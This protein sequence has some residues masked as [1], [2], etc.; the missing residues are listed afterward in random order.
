MKHE[1][2]YSNYKQ[3]VMCG[4]YLPL[5]YTLDYCQA[6]EDDVLFKEVREYIRSH[7]VSEYELAEVFDIPQAK[8]RKWIQEGRIEYANADN[9]IIGT[10]CARCGK[11]VSFGTYCTSCM[12]IMNGGQERRYISYGESGD[13][14][15]MRFLKDE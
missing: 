10:V 9:K 4:R 15:R 8:V 3:C 2:Q 14:G 5:D 6:C 12:R 13:D 11:P 1:A 7:D